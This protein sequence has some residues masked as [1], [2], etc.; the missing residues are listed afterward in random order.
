MNDR[1][2]Q[3]THIN[4]KHKYITDK[5]LHAFFK[6]VYMQL[7]CGFLEKETEIYPRIPCQSASNQIKP[8]HYKNLY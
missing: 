7:G 8:V 6:I 4:L 5:I 1:T 3:A 2:L